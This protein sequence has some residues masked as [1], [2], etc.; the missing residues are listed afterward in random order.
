LSEL[1]TRKKMNTLF[2]TKDNLKTY[3]N[4]LTI[5]NAN[6]TRYQPHGNINI[7]RGKRIRDVIAPL[8]A[9]PKGRDIETAVDRKWTNYYWLLQLADFITIPPD[10]S[11]FRTCRNFDQRRHMVEEDCIKI[12]RRH[13]G[14]VKET[15]M[16]NS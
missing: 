10:R 8:F 4:I 7:T 12:L 15:C 2:I 1:L 3:K 9:K 16:R 11:P 14:V 6:W 13:Q 5:T